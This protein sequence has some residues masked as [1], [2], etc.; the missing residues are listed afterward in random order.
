VGHVLGTLGRGGAERLVVDLVNRASSRYHHRIFC[1]KEGGPLEAEITSPD[2]GVHVLGIAEGRQPHAPLLLARALRRERLD[3]VHSHNWGT[4]LDGAVGARLAGVRTRVHSVHGMYHEDT[5]RMAGRRVWI[6][7]LV[8]PSYGVWTAVSEDLKRR[9]VAEA[10]VPAERIRVVPSGVDLERYRPRTDRAELRARW[11]AGE[12]DF[13]VACMGTLYWVKDH[14]SLV[15]AAGALKDGGRPV[16][17]VVVG[18]G[19]L[20]GE[21]QAEIDRRGLGPTFVLAGRVPDPAEVLGAADAFVLP[22]LIEGVSVAL[23]EAMACGLPC[24]A[25]RVGGTPEVIGDGVQGR[26]VPPR[27]PAALATAIGGLAA[28]RAAARAMGEAARRRAEEWFGLERMVSTFEAVYEE[29]LSGAG[30]PRVI[31]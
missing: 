29:A 12:G 4:F 22:S 31:A 14:A 8:G 11:G 26:L 5:R 20:R 17:V 10:G 23:L 24:V 19:P 16:R 27:D 21:I 30:R 6:H 3:V 7:R 2:V 13:L 9:Y 28:D 15:Q 1:L 18:D 25:T